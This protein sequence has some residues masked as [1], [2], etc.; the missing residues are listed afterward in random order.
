MPNLNKLL[1]LEDR[2]YFT[3][4]KY[5]EFLLTPEFF[6]NLLHA[7]SPYGL[8]LESLAEKK[9]TTLLDFKKLKC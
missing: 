2:L 6:C 3:E 4:N 9:F 5:F 8:I 1:I 7:V